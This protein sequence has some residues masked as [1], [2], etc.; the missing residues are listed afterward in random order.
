M[1]KFILR[2]VGAGVVTLLLGSVIVFSVIHLVPGDPIS[3]AMGT[4]YNPQVANALRALYG[5]N[6]P[7]PVQYWDWLTSLIRGNLGYSL[8]TQ[9]SI[10]AQLA[11]RLP[12]TLILLAGG[13]TIAL[14]ISVPCGILSARYSGGIIDRF[15]VALTSSALSVPQFW[16]GLLLIGFISV[17]LHLVPAGGYYPFSSGV[18]TAIE[19]LILPWIT[20]ALPMSA[21][22]TRTLRSSMMDVLGENYVRTG[23]SRGLSDRSVL[24]AYVLRNA[25]IPVTTVVGL[26]I[27]SLLGGA[28]I[29]EQV[30]SY[31]GMGN[32]MV[33]AITQ[34]DYPVLQASALVFTV[35]FV[36]VNIVVDLIY[37][38]LD[39]RIR[40]SQ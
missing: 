10:T 30:F 17:Q 1:G 36:I 11:Q 33:N 22:I 21:F 37:G 16:V 31:P 23:R 2:R 20:I 34:R 32:Y 12:R 7:L 24:M 25:S 18:G 29:V 39:P 14:L 9:T 13:V 8:T 38:I 26:E 3:A 27:G 4:E 19:A 6:H 35:G 28:I 40:M 15:V 5:L